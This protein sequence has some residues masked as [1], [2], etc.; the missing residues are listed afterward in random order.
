MVMMVLSDR[1][2]PSPREEET[3][4]TQMEFLE[5][6]R[7]RHAS[8]LESFR[9]SVLRIV[10]TVRCDTSSAQDTGALAD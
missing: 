8:H 4:I 6:L 2:T 5:M 10:Q 9:D 1:N 7:M 3:E